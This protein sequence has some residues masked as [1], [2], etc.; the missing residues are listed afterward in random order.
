MCRRYGGL[1][2]PECED[3]TGPGRSGPGPVSTCSA[4]VDPPCGA[5]VR[6]ARR[7]DRQHIQDLTSSRLRSSVADS[8]VV[9]FGSCNSANSPRIASSE[10]ATRPSRVVAFVPAPDRSP[11]VGERGVPVQVQVLVPQPPDEARDAAVLRRL[12][13]WMDE[14]ATLRR[15]AHSSSARPPIPGPSSTTMLR[16]SSRESAS[17]SSTYTARSPGGEGATLMCR[18][19]RVNSSGACAPVAASTGVAWRGCVRPPTSEWA[20]SGRIL[21]A[22]AEK[23]RRVSGSGRDAA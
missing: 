13:G 22:S 18:Q 3:R 23:S 20:S 4:I 8:R 1:L 7:P 5:R 11:R 12:P 14:S 17:C 6:R 2:E 21:S 19:S 15:C 16:G 9:V 10:A